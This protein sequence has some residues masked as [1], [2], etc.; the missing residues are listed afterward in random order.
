MT[1]PDKSVRLL[2]LWS[3]TPDQPMPLSLGQVDQPLLAAKRDDASPSLFLA[4]I[5][6]SGMAIG[7]PAAHEDVPL[8]VDL[9]RGSPLFCLLVFE[10]EGKP[11][12]FWSTCS[13]NN[14]RWSKKEAAHLVGLEF[15]NWTVLQPGERSLKWLHASPAKGVPPILRWIESMGVRQ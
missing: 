11:V 5:S 6:A 8:P 7:F 2:S 10:M 14:V 3:I 1:P 15:T 13:V 12:T 9:K 4:N